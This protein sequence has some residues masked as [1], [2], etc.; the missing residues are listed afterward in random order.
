M[1][2]YGNNGYANAHHIKLYVYIVSLITVTPTVLLLFMRTEALKLWLHKFCFSSFDGA[3]WSVYI[4]F[5]SWKG[6]R[7]P[8][9]SHE[10]RLFLRKPKFQCGV[11]K[12]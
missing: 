4:P 7:L 1:L 8:S 9:A 3:E 11:P 12:R 2:F 6:K 5:V 10:I